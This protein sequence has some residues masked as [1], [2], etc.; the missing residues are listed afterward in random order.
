MK[1]AS[2]VRVSDKVLR[3]VVSEDL[4][5]VYDRYERQR[6]FVEATRQGS[7]DV[8]YEPVTRASDNR[9]PETAVKF[10]M[11]DASCERVCER[12]GID[13]RPLHLLASDGLSFAEIERKTG[14]RRHQVYAHLQASLA[15]R[16]LLDGIVPIEK[17]RVY[18]GFARACML[19]KS[20][21]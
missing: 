1:R 19:K 17:A 10:V 16:G 15:V 18:A 8:N 11:F 20:M 13:T 6:A 21:G 7:R 4:I 12:L 5:V 2:R 14:L 3:R 9:G